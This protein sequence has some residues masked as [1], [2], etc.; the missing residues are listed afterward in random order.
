[1]KRAEQAARCVLTPWTVSQ[2][3]PGKTTTMPDAAI[4]LERMW[5]V[6]ANL[7]SRS[8]GQL[9]LAPGLGG[10]HEWFSEAATWARW[11][12]VAEP[13]RRGTLP[14]TSNPAARMTALLVFED[15]DTVLT[16]SVRR[17]AQQGPPIRDDAANRLDYH[18]WLS[19]LLR[20]G[21]LRITCTPEGEVADK[22]VVDRIERTL[23][24][25]PSDYCQNSCRR[26]GSRSSHRD[27][28]GPCLCAR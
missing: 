12:P 27:A 9:L 19:R 18:A 6:A 25:L 28:R 2:I 14:G 15:L 24:E 13:G 17:P 7:C 3:Q 1:M 22:A 8:R 4:R 20:C 26:R 23:I 16:G 10:N 21:C 11:F 5:S